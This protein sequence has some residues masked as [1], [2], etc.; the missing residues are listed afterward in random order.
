[1]PAEYAQLLHAPVPLDYCPHCGR[2][3]F[4]PFMRGEVQRPRRVLGFIGAARPNCALICGSCKFIVA[5]ESP[6]SSR[7]DRVSTS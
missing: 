3:P 6:G 7:I 2:S 1:M 4:V 5:Y